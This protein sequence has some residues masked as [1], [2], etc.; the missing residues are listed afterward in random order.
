MYS[1]GGKIQFS[2]L[3]ELLHKEKEPRSGKSSHRSIILPPFLP[4]LPHEKRSSVHSLVKRS[5]N[6]RNLKFNLEKD[7]Q[8]NFP[9]RNSL[10]S[11]NVTIQKETKRRKKKKIKKNSIFLIDRSDQCSKNLIGKAECCFVKRDDERNAVQREILFRGVPDF[12]ACVFYGTKC[13]WKSRCVG[14]KALA[15]LATL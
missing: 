10:N 7:V 2:L 8:A 13:F 3:I 15:D 14:G 5:K 1:L 12:R 11:Q 4:P 9:M 6:S